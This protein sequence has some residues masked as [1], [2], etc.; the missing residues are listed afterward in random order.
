MLLT[1]EYTVNRTKTLLT[2]STFSGVKDQLSQNDIA[3]NLLSPRRILVNYVVL[4]NMSFFYQNCL[5]LNVPVFASFK[6]FYNY[7]F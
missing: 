7:I 5:L 1:K 3:Y 2:D 6:S 4:L